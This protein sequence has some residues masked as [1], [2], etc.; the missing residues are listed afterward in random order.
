ML[1]WH[2]PPEWFRP[3]IL[4]VRGERSAAGRVRGRIERGG[5]LPLI[6]PSGTFSPNQSHLIVHAAL[7]EKGSLLG[8]AR[9]R[10]C[11]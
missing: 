6:R 1:H 3:Q 8:N 10:R 2:A 5:A 7:G 11:G 4:G 9:L